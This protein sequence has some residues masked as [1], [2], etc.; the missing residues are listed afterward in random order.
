M[1]EA[2]RPR[3]VGLAYRLLG[4][5][6]DAEDV[7]Q[8]A[9][10]RWA[11]ADRAAVDNPA[12]WLTTVTSRIGLDRLR[13]RSRERASYV[14]PWLP[15]P[16]VEPLDLAAAEEP[17]VTAD[18]RP[19]VDPADR[20][21]LAD[22]LTT[23]FLVLLEEL[24]PVERLVILLVDVFGEP[25]RLAAEVTGRS[26]AA[27]RQLAVRARRKLRATT[28]TDVSDAEAVVRPAVLLASGL[29][30]G[31][32]RGEGVDR[33]ARVPVDG[34][35]ALGDGG[36]E[37]RPPVDPDGDLAAVPRRRRDAAS[38]EAVRVA[39]TLLGAVATGDLDAAM[40]L[41]APEVVLVS[42]GGADHHAARRPVLG[43]DRVARLLVNLAKRVPEGA[44]LVPGLVNGEPGVVVRHQG[45]TRF[46]LAIGVDP[47]GVVDHVSV[48]VNPD[49]L[50]AVDDPPPVR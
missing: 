8:E 5:L 3:L 27:V 39:T 2:E 9:W 33:P 45:R 46:V 47:T 43:A 7:V 16:L 26:E 6:S 34:A 11:G 41:L 14:G 31:G 37:G 23:A 19:S 20:A 10:L 18:V 49:K 32:R 25:F 24:S 13:A 38:P 4:S 29:D 50:Q 17:A 12:A 42:D 36:G 15:E 44:E 30:L 22:S 40:A 1:F 28:A 48:V 35:V 21:A